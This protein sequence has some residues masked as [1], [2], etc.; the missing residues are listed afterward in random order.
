LEFIGKFSIPEQALPTHSNHMNFSKKESGSPRRPRTLIITQYSLPLN[1]R[2]MNAYQ[3]VFDGSNFADITLV[4]R[5]GEKVS[6]QIAG[7]V[8]VI[9]AP[10][11]NRWLFLICCVIVA[12]W[13]KLWRHEVILTD[14]S[15]F[16]A[17]GFLAKYL[18]GYFWVMDVWD[19]PR[20][21]AGEH[22]EG[23]KTRFSD[24]LVFGRRPTNASSSTTLSIFPELRRTPRSGPAWTR[25]CTSPTDDPSSTRPW[26]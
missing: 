17:V 18:F 6:D 16:A 5:S 3:R 10:V 13:L 25:H 2:N 22:E 24:R 8:R 21:R 23:M 14:P 12:G 4:I 7:K 26:G 11:S 1:K 9:Q 15:G 20:W 19:R